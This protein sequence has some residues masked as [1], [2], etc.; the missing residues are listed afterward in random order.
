[1]DYEEIAGAA[2]VAGRRSVA[3]SRQS[4]RNAD[5]RHRSRL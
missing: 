4:A 5:S 2:P 1:M 3:G